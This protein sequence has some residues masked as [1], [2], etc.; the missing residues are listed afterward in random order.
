AEAPEAR[1]GS[2]D[3]CLALAVVTLAAFDS[4]DD[5][6]ELLELTHEIRRHR[7]SF[8]QLGDVDLLLVPGEPPAAPACTV[9]ARPG[10]GELLADHPQRQELVSLQ[11]QDRRQALHVVR[12][13]EAIT[14]AR[15]ARR[16]EPLVL[17]VPDL[18]DGDVREG[19]AEL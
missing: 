19:L 8:A 6:S 12:R 14:T 1:A 17:E 16:D 7:G 10:S 3:V 18:G 4:R 15:A 11:S 5:H 9:R 2:R 13:E